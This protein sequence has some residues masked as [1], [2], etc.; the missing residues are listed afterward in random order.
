MGSS[1]AVPVLTRAVGLMI[2]LLG[3]VKRSRLPRRVSPCEAGIS[4]EDPGPPSAQALDLIF[5]V[6]PATYYSNHSITVCLDSE[7]WS[8]H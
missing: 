8:V 2:D 1:R 3:C 7:V 5:I 4:S 6:P